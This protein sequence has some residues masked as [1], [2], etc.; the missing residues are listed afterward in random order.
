MIGYQPHRGKRCVYGEAT[1][2][3]DL[4]NGQLDIIQ[5]LIPA[6]KTCGRPRSLDPRQ[7]VAV[8]LGSYTGFGNLLG[9]HASKPAVRGQLGSHG[10]AILLLGFRYSQARKG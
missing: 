10:C 9:T 3:T 5:D 4:T 2:P 1:V 6:A 8:L 7:V